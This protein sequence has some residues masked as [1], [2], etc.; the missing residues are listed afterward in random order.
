MTYAGISNVIRHQGR[1]R[2]FAA[3]HFPA[4]LFRS[5]SFDLFQLLSDHNPTAPVTARIKSE[6]APGFV[7]LTPLSTVQRYRSFCPVGWT[8]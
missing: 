2:P 5:S 7:T 4:F 8:E 3:A 1:A 6:N